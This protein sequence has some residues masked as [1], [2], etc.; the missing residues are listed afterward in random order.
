MD[1]NVSDN[2]VKAKIK[3]VAAKVSESGLYPKTASAM[4]K[5]PYF[6][7]VVVLYCGLSFAFGIWHPLW[8]IFL[9]LPIYYRVATACKAKT[10]KAF[11]N[12]LPIPEAVVALYLI[13]SFATGAWKY[14]W[15]LFLIIPVYYWFV[16]V[17]VKGK[18]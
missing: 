14:T 10:K 1:N 2:S 5:F 7:I 4:M 3:N 15:M 18:E 17:Y 16:S 6:L 12:L 11:C 13:I 8:I 9:T